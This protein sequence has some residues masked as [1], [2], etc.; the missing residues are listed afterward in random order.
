[1][2]FSLCW[3]AGAWFA[4]I[5][6]AVAQQAVHVSLGDNAGPALG[7]PAGGGG[8]VWNSWTSD[9]GPLRDSEGNET[10]VEVEATGEGPGGGWWCDLRLLS[11]GM[12]CGDGESGALVIS[13]LDPGARYDV[14]LACAWGGLGGR[15]T[16]SL[17][18]PADPV[19]PQ[20]A[21]NR[22]APNA[23]A[24]VAGKN[25]VVFPDL[26]PDAGGR[27]EFTYA[28]TGDPG[29][30]NGVQIVRA[31]RELETYA[32][33]AARAEQNLTPGTNDGPGDDPDGDGIDNL[34][35]FV[36]G[37][38]PLTSDLEILPELRRTADGWA[39]QFRRRNA[40][41]PPGLEQW[42]EFSGDMTKWERI[43]V[44]VTADGK[45]EISPD[46]E[47]DEI[48]VLLP[49]DEKQMFIRLKA[50]DHPYTPPPSQS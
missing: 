19:S 14:Y 12:Y 48:R 11:G 25:Y 6:Q 2:L 13:G 29:A 4:A 30:L 15:T 44:P 3:A 31:E 20:T 27:I 32:G 21:D 45:V 36:L 22:D 40:A 33:W 28:G 5:P 38:N 17:V 7:G 46:G 16:V 10:T 47:F 1:M 37:G 50:A 42:L 43:P 35:E 34:L 49:A 9:A 41:R 18:N 23:D 8:K 39:F 24:W 26:A